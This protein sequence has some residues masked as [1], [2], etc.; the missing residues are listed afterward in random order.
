DPDRAEAVL[1]VRRGIATLFALQIVYV[2]ADAGTRSGHTTELLTFCL[3]DLMLLVLAFAA[4]FTAG[5]RRHWQA[6]TL[7]L[8][9]VL[10]ATAALRSLIGHSVGWALFVVILFSLG[11]SVWVPWGGRWQALLNICC[12]AVLRTSVGYGSND[13]PLVWYQWVG[14]LVTLMLT[15]VAASY[16]DRYRRRSSGSEAQTRAIVEGAF[17]GIITMDADGL[18]KSWN[19]RA[20]S[21][22]GWSREEA[23]GRKFFELVIAGDDGVPVEDREKKSLGS[24]GQ[25][26]RPDR[27]VELTAIH[28][29]GRR[30]PLELAVS[31][32]HSEGS[33]LFVAFARDITERKWAEEERALLASIIE[34]AD[35]AIF[36]VTLDGV[37]NSWNPGAEKLYGYT[38]EEVVGQSSSI[39]IPPALV[40]Q[41][42]QLIESIVLDERT[43]SI[44]TQRLRSD[45]TPVEVCLNASP[46]YN[47][48]GRIT[49]V[50]V[51]TSD[52]TERKRVE[53]ELRESEE[54]F[55]KVFESSLD[56]IS[57]N[58]FTDGRYI[59]VNENFVKY[60]GYTREEVVGKTPRE[61]KVWAKREDFAKVMAELRTKGMVHN[62]EGEYVT[63]DG[64]HWSG[65]FSAVVI[66]LN[67]Q[68]CIL[69]FARD[70]TARKQAERELRES[71][72]TFRTV[73][74]ASTDAITLNTSPGAK[75]A[76]VNEEFV[77]LTGYS[78]D[79]V[80]GR[81]T[82]ELGIWA[83]RDDARMAVRELEE[84]G[85]VRNL[86]VGF[87]TKTG[88]TIAASFSAVVMNFHGERCVLSFVRDLGD[89]KRAEQTRS[90]LASIVESADEAI[91]SANFAQEITTWNPGAERLYGYSTA[92]IVG[93]P[94]SVLIPSE[95]LDEAAQTISD[96]AL[97]GG[98]RHLETQRL[99]K[100]GS[101][102]D[103]SMTVSP[104]FTASGVL[105]GTSAIAHDITERKRV[106]RDL[107]DSEEMFRRMFEANLDA[108]TINSF[109][110]GTYL[111]VN[112][113][114]LRLMGYAREEMLGKKPQDF[115]AW[116]KR[117]DI[118]R[119][120]EGLRTRGVVYNLESEFVAKSGSHW[121]GLFSAVVINLNNQP[122]IL[123]FVRDI[124]WLKRQ[125]RELIEAREQALAAA[126]AK[127][128]FL[129]TMSH[130]IRTPMNAIIGMGELL[131]ESSLT[132]EQRGYV[133]IARSAGNALLS[134]INDILDLSKI[135]SG[136]SV[137]EEI[138]FDLED[139]IEETVESLAFR[140]HEKGLDLL[141]HIAPDVARGFKGDPTRLRQVLTNLI[142]NAV[143]F[144]GQGEVVVRVERDPASDSPG[145]LRFSVCDTG[146]GI[147]SGKQEA[148]FESFTQVDSSITRRY[149]GSGLG[150]TISKR[151][152]ELMG[153]RI[154]LESELGKGSIFY[155][156]TDLQV[157]SPAQQ[158]AIAPRIDLKGM[159]I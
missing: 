85:I 129:A 102:V 49:G 32:A 124:T 6:I 19:P 55:R 87:R 12:L 155:F 89:R 62:V 125:E 139:L 56:S 33:S 37:I 144:T 136:H 120:M 20:E 109:N 35:D 98:V 152:V 135:E 50:A 67:N 112:D 80:I 15:P 114:F 79:E 99:K 69:S 123:S 25:W 111:G 23:I 43:Q 77:K 29:D 115:N 13:D 31:A 104:I 103:V 153:G 107:R 147:P 108:I 88:A 106:E 127:S 100:D 105:A 7:A 76:A 78:R 47:D 128:E 59:D 3:G 48:A 137:L 93:R 117:E 1:Q 16:L 156:T 45:G 18:V 40:S 53:R 116:A 90:L 118:V 38:T 122:C 143:K 72:N 58:S 134:L 131:W 46:I 14:L 2:V 30:F 65:L 154:W 158:S 34:S 126:R 54:K 5:F 51:I 42:H 11:C 64:V 52:I 63:K 142:G 101:V 81:T 92:E 75:Y 27:I 9:A 57:I 36:S 41:G 151:L 8:C 68:P 94:R 24:M 119:V 4:T 44:E 150:L 146:I 96:L 26:L 132:S 138:D 95:R 66:N 61:L 73:F 74:E 157:V 22:F 60:M 17:D 70:I 130:E 140:A 149:G 113:N 71:E 133:R 110:D 10:L 159:K 91:Y 148:V 82:T 141:S 86:E 21:I 145:G 84:K 28:R 83:S 39:L 121:S 97:K